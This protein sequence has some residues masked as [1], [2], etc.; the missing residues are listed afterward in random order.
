MTK[1]PVATLL[2]MPSSLRHLV[3]QTTLVRAN[4]QSRLLSTTSTDEALPTPP[5]PISYLPT[6]S[7]IPDQRAHPSPPPPAAALAASTELFTGQRPKFLYAAP[8]FLHIPL[9]SHTPAVCILWRSNV[10]KSTLINALSGRSSSSAGRIHGNASKRAGLAMTSTKA[11][12]T[13]TLNGYGFG[14]PTKASPQRR[15][16]R[17]EDGPAF[18]ASRADK[19][20]EKKRREPPPAHGL[21]MVD[22]PGYGLNSKTEWGIEIAKYLAR[23][24]MLRGAVLLIDSVAGVKDGDRMVLGLLRDANVRT[25]VVLTKA[26]KLGYGRG[27]GA[28]AVQKMCLSVWDELR[29]AEQ[30]SLTWVEGQGWAPEI[31]VTGAGDPKHGGI[32]VD[33]ARLAIC[34]MAGLVKD[35]RNLALAGVRPSGGKI[36]S[37]EDLFARAPAHDLPRASF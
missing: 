1:L 34:Q 20:A 5:V 14:P 9:N 28:A 18:G 33:G 32:G 16:E 19:R 15:E 8:R 36:V 10:G 23:R 24:A 7:N 21:I 13:T 12:C 3:L 2:A 4:F 27:S 11:G 25:T 35:T 37:F 31:W 22:M 29:A 30:N 6:P 17:A 26:D